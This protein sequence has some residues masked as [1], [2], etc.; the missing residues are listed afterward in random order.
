VLSQLSQSRDFAHV[1]PN[2]QISLSSN[3]TASGAHSTLNTFKKFVL[4]RQLLSIHD[5]PSLFNETGA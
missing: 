5:G 2:V 4:L 3:R 1:L